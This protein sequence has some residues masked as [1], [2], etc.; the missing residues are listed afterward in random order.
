[1]KQYLENHKMKLFIY[2]MYSFTN[3]MLFSI[4]DILP[5]SVR[6]IIF[7]MIL[8]HNGKENLIDYK[9]YFRYPKRI[10]L[11]NNVAINRGCRLYASYYCKDAEIVIKDNVT[12]APYV[13]IFTATH[14]YRFLD[15]PDIGKRVVIHPHV[16]IGA[17]SIILPG[18][19]VGEGAVIGAGSVVTRDIPSYSIAVG[20]PARVIGPRNL[21]DDR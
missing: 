21:T 10:S 7:T 15:L 13:S 14:D 12:L 9:T 3:T 1:M 5:M 18:V 20:V 11:G 4:L 16:W 6:N 19:E 8:K 2:G 17:N